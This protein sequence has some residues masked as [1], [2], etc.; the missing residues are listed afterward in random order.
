M[1]VQR[2]KK[3]YIYNVVGSSMTTLLDGRRVWRAGT[4][5]GK[6]VLAGHEALQGGAACEGTSQTVFLKATWTI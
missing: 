4:R 1:Y 5:H 6:V 2:S 3:V